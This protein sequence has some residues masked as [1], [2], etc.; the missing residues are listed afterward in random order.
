MKILPLFKILNNWTLLGSFQMN[1]GNI[2]D[3]KVEYSSIIQ[4]KEM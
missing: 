4:K 3:K 1:T 2:Y